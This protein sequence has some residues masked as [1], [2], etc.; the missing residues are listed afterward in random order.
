[1]I[2]LIEKA[3]KF[4]RLDK[5]ELVCLLSCNN[6]VAAELFAAADRICRKY[7]GDGIYLRA[8]LE[9]S[10]YCRNNCLYCGIRAGNST[11]LRYRQ[12]VDDIV[13]AAVFA[14]RKGLETIVLQSGEDTFFDSDKMC[15]I[16]KRIKALDMAVTLSLGEKSTEEYA[17]YKKAG[18]DRYLLR[19]ET[20]DEAVY[21]AMHPNMSLK[22]R[23][24]CLYDLKILNYE[25]GTGTLVGLPNQTAESLAEDILFYVEAGADMVGIGPLIP[26]P[27]TPL[28]SAKAGDIMTVMKM[29]ALTR[30]LLPKANIP[31]VTA[32]ETLHKGSRDKVLAAGAN[33]VM[34]NVNAE[35]LKEKYEIYPNKYG[36]GKSAA[37]VIKN[38]ENGAKVIGKRVLKSKGNSKAF[39]PA[40]VIGLTG[41]IACGKSYVS[42]LLAKKGF[43]VVDCDKIV[44]EL[45]TYDEDVMKKIK[46]VFPLA[47]RNVDGKDVLDRA[48]LSELTLAKE[49]GLAE[50]EKIM[51]PLVLQRVRELI[52]FFKKQGKKY[53]VIDAPLLFEAGLNA[54]CTLVI[55]VYADD[56]VS[57][58]RYL[59]REGTSKER[60]SVLKTRQLPL[61][62]KMKM[63]DVCIK[64]ENE[65]ET[66]AAVDKFVSECVNMGDVGEK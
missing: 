13:Q 56:E 52:V 35:N 25:V 55:C 37:E 47:F 31:A 53:I 64:S 30:L 54:L 36:I 21:K 39:T 57:L 5:D 22:N 16:I 43:A 1:M 8:L 38:I 14:K 19:I 58:K 48:K 10:D 66:A 32:V 18:A 50:M 6:D 28:A 12:S 7:I 2:G 45:Q 40:V 61:S 49:D 51:I 59:A 46:A 62:E 23:K 29:V 65:S 42:S 9:F 33:V 3:E 11:C 15:D 24:R 26:H 27:Q 63:S 20:T 44:R 60:L 4:H 17:A 41:G 34:P